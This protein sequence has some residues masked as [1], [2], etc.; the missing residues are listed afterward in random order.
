MASLWRSGLAKS[1]NAPDADPDLEKKP[2]NEDVET[3]D[4]ISDQSRL[5]GV[6]GLKYIKSG[7][8]SARSY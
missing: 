2:P 6:K 1:K 8:A 7:G 5:L 4:V 3:H